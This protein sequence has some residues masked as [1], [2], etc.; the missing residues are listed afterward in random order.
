VHPALGIFIRPTGL[1]VTVYWQGECWDLLLSVDLEARSTGMG[2][3]CEFCEPDGRGHF[4]TLESLWADHFFNPLADWLRTVLMP[5]R[6]LVLEC[7]AERGATWVSVS[8]EEHPPTVGT[9]GVVLPVH[10]HG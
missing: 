1:D 10:L 5:G 6:F 9:D 4:D 7:T 3:Y 2:W 8:R